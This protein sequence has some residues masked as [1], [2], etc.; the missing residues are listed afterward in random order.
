MNPFRINI[1]QSENVWK[2]I[3]R[4]CLPGKPVL[5]YLPIGYLFAFL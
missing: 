1:K 5:N 4:V 2:G 3:K